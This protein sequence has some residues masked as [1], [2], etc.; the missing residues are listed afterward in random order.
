MRLFILIPLLLFMVSCNG[1]SDLEPLTMDDILPT[2]ENYKEGDRKEKAAPDVFYFDSLQIFS[3]HISDTLGIKRV[4]VIVPDSVLFPD[5]FMSKSK[6][7]WNGRND[8]SDVLVSVWTYRDSLEMK[9]ALFNWLDCFGRRCA[10][11]QLYE[12]KK[13]TNKSFLLYAT[14]KKMI[15]LSASSSIDVQS[16]LQNLQNSIPKEKVLYV[17][18]QGIGRKTEWWEYIEKKWTTKK[19]N[20]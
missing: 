13:I 2:S 12:E 15:Y 1:K 19:V 20:E 6:E 18:S 3:Q 5:R 14:E 7:K 16:V 9:N 10:T 17:V 11:L 8:Y 4:S